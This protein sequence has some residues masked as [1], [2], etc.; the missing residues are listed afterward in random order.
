MTRGNKLK[1]NDRLLDFIIELDFYR[2]SFTN[3]LLEI[4]LRNMQRVCQGING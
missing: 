1:F 3:T 4:S 2:D